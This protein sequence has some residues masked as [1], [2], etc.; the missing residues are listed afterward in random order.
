MNGEDWEWGKQCDTIFVDVGPNKM[1][2]RDRTGDYMKLAV[3]VA[4]CAVMGSA[5]SW[6]AIQRVG[7]QVIFKYILY[8]WQTQSSTD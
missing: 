7:G 3:W 6:T 2:L 1:V 5:V 8:D 4:R